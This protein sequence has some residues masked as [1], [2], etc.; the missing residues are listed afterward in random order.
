M[1]ASFLGLEAVSFWLECKGQCLICN[2]LK[3]NTKGKNREKNPDNQILH[4]GEFN[5]TQFLKQKLFLK[6]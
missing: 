3:T 1:A 6:L 4:P 5:I 2:V